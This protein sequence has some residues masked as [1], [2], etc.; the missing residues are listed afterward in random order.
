VRKGGAGNVTI[1][2]ATGVTIN[3]PFGNILDTT[4]QWA[5]LVKVDTDTWDLLIA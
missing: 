2:G 5:V 1:S 3:A 4:G